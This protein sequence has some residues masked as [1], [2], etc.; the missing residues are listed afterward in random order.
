M[1]EIDDNRKIKFYRNI[2]KDSFPNINEYS[3]N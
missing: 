2:I 1:G 3:K